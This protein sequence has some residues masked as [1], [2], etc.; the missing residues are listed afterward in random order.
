MVLSR[1]EQGS[2]DEPERCQEEK[3]EPENGP[4]PFPWWAKA[5]VVP[6]GPV[7]FSVRLRWWGGAFGVLRR[8][9]P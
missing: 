1:R 4:F 6:E 5:V 8:A 3:E 9:V 2:H 7:P